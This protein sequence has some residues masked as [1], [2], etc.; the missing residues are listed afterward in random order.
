[1]TNDLNNLNLQNK[2]YN[3]TNIVLV[4]KGQGLHIAK[5]G[6]TQ[7]YTPTSSFT[8]NNVLLVL[9]IQKNLL[10]VQQFDVDNCMYF[11]FHYHFFLV[12]DYLEKVHHQGQLNNGLYQF[13]TSTQTPQV[14]STIHTST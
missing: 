10:S 4:E 2:D 3:G 9:K 14:F 6:S 13:T 7:L 5:I 12:K 1:M 8:L 11:E